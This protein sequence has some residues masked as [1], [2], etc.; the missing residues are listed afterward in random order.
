MK[1]PRVKPAWEEVA[2]N[3]DHPDQPAAVKFLEVVSSPAYKSMRDPNPIA[4]D[5][6]FFFAGWKRAHAESSLGGKLYEETAAG[7]TQCELSKSVCTGLQEALSRAQQENEVLKARLAAAVRTPGLGPVRCARCDGAFEPE[8]VIPLC[9]DFFPMSAD[10]SFGVDTIVR[11]TASLPNDTSEENRREGREPQNLCKS[12]LRE[13][14]ESSATQLA[15]NARLRKSISTWYLRRR[16]LESVEACEASTP[17]EPR[18][19]SR[20]CES[21]GAPGEPS[22]PT[23]GTSPGHAGGTETT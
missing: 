9:S 1:K 15:E 17:T 23:S 7:A 8:D 11:L 21:P 18:E 16:R 6:G 5:W 2:L 22:S 10:S 12:C 19:G 3:P 14:C 13:I 4:R 20:S